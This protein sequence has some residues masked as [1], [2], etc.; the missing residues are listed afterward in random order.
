MTLKNNL[1]KNSFIALFVFTICSAGLFCVSAQEDVTTNE[2]SNEISDSSNQQKNE[3]TPPP[4][5]Q[6]NKDT[7]T[8]SEE[9]VKKESEN[10]NQKEKSKNQSAKKSS[11]ELI[12]EGDNS[13]IDSTKEQKIESIES[14][15]NDL[16]LDLPEV[17]DS[18]IETKP[19]TIANFFIKNT[20]PNI[21][22]TIIAWVFILGGILIIIKSIVSSFKTSKKYTPSR[23]SKHTQ[24]KNNHYNL[25]I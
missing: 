20:T 13:D 2:S 11:I 18:E 21:I 5:K 8:K 24:R 9:N 23:N 10:N 1:L 3:S 4:P 16:N 12:P 6:S 15:E 14:N 22:K 25:K 19:S 17:N 7:I